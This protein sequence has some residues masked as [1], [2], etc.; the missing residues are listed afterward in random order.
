[1]WYH[2]LQVLLVVAA[3]VI[4]LGVRYALIDRQ[5]DL[6]RFH[7]IYL[8]QTIPA[9]TLRHYTVRGTWLA[10]LFVAVGTLALCENAA[11]PSFYPYGRFSVAQTKAQAITAPTATLV[12]HEAY[13]RFGVVMSEPQ[14][15]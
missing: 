5:A 3:I 1:M 12:H 13:G 11:P 4:A 9:K 14:T 7:R 6:P 10:V 15:H 8:L 2:T